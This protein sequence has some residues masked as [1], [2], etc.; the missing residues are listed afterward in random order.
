MKP[1]SWTVELYGIYLF[2]ALVLLVAPANLPVSQLQV[3]TTHQG[4]A[5]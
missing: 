5:C 3:S 1:H 2:I 4:L